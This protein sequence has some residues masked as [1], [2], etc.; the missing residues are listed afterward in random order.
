[1]EEDTCGS[2]ADGVRVAAFFLSCA[3]FFFIR[4]AD[5]APLRPPERGLVGGF[6]RGFF[7]R[8]VYRGHELA[9]GVA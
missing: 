4:A 1:M 7:A 9:M 8:G 3:S 2:V 5:I 6:S